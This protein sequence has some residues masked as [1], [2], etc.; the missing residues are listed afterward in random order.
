[1]A[2]P[3]INSPEWKSLVTIYGED[4]AYR[5][6]EANDQ[7][8]P[9]NIVTLTLQD[10]ERDLGLR[11]P[12]T[13]ER[14]TYPKNEMD[15]VMVM[16][17]DYNNLLGDSGFFAKL[18]QKDDMLSIGIQVDK[19]N[20]NNT[21]RPFNTTL[22]QDTLGYSSEAVLIGLGLQQQNKE[23][24]MRSLRRFSDP[25]LAT[26]ARNILK[27]NP[28]ISITFDTEQAT[29]YMPQG[30][31][32]NINPSTLASIAKNSGKFLPEVYEQ[33]LVHELVHS[34]TA[35]GIKNA[36]GI[37]SSK[38]QVLKELHAR[39][40]EQDNINPYT[41]EFRDT[42]EANMYKRSPQ[43]FVAEALSNPK[44]RDYL[45]EIPGG[46]NR[47][48]WGK[49]KDFILS[50]IFGTASRSSLY[51]NVFDTVFSNDQVTQS[52]AELKYINS[53]PGLN[54]DVS[55]NFAA[56]VDANE[57]SAKKSV[58]EKE[59]LVKILEKKAAIL[60]K[61]NVTEGEQSEISKRLSETARQL[62]AAEADLALFKFVE[63]AIT[64]TNKVYNKVKELREEG[65]TPEE[66][67]KYLRRLAEAYAY[68]TPFSEVE[69]TFDYIEGMKFGDVTIDEDYKRRVIAPALQNIRSVRKMYKEKAMQVLPKFLNEHNNDPTLD[70]S[71]IARMLT[72]VDDDIWNL[73]RWMSGIADSP[74]QVLAL[75]DRAVSYQRNR[76]NRS[77]VEFVNT[78]LKAV[79]K[80][81]EAYKASQGISKTDFRQYYDFM[82][83]KDKE[84]NL[85]GFYK[86]FSKKPDSFSDAEWNFYKLFIDNYRGSQNYLPTSNMRGLGFI[87]ILKSGTERR[88]SAVKGVKSAITQ[89]KE[90]L[91]DQFQRRVDDVDYAE[92]YIDEKG[93]LFYFLPTRYTSKIEADEIDDISLDLESNLARF[94][95]MARNYNAMNNIMT[96][97]EAAKFLVGERLVTNKKGGVP[98]VD[99]LLKQLRDNP[100]DP[101]TKH[102]KVGKDSNA[103]ARLSDY[104]DMVF[105][106]KRKE[107][108]GNIFGI[109]GLDKGK[110]LDAL[111]RFTGI[112]SLAFNLYSGINNATL[113]QVM[114]YI[115][116][117]SGQFYD[118]SDWFWSQG[119]YSKLVFNEFLSDS[120]R[121]YKEGK[122]GIWMDSYDI[123]QEFDEFGNP[124][125]SKSK[126]DTV[127]GG[128]S[129]FAQTSG[130]HMIQT[131]LAISMARH[132]R[133][134]NNEIFSYNDYLLKENLADT[135]ENKAKFEANP[136]VYDSLVLEEGKVRVSGGLKVGEMEKLSERIKGVF[137][138]LHG[139]Y[140]KKDI[141]ALN[142]W[143]LTRLMMMFRKWIKPGFDRR[144]AAGTFDGKFRF[145]QRLGANVIGTYTATWNFVRQLLKEHSLSLKAIAMAGRD[146]KNLPAWKQQ[147]I[148]RTLNEAMFVAGSFLVTA[149]LASIE[150]DDEDTP[151]IASMME[152]QSRRLNSELLFYVNVNDT[153]KI[154]RSPM[155][156]LSV[157][158]K[159]IKAVDQTMPWNI[160]EEYTRGKRTGEL[161]VYKRWGDLIPYYNQLERL[162][163]IEEQI[164][165]LRQ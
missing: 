124:L 102:T 103:Y 5:I 49:I 93:E 26:I 162:T 119:E 78:K 46:D 92:E 75:I 3:N 32:V 23:A 150:W 29:K 142:K 11:N 135:K 159:T 165:W 125:K 54:Y 12:D 57:K 28:D 136:N 17:N 157:V 41:D 122:I 73:T 143:G 87:A 94:M 25:Q 39:F 27:V 31:T 79:A 69:E 15:E 72:S 151:I 4:E 55:Y 60:A 38:G 64:E 40:L 48:L 10:K 96:E 42:K 161:K 144:F 45:N 121:R 99:K 145:D 83:E 132:H 37:T 30:N 114:N 71:D 65:K 134:I 163:R 51:D 68:I 104:L 146:F 47:T 106:G 13:N 118:K 2:C 116:G 63:F 21:D 85:T 35:L 91:A 153:L 149:V 34:I 115:E 50:F 130:E 24:V 56:S 107:D 111:G 117:A 18:I 82:L 120:T 67:R 95:T 66:N 126:L 133:I 158:E 156:S 155:A 98:I 89:G 14:I 36:G 84:G 43:E 74:D 22:K 123:L 112:T 16:V 80:D 154:M 147:A 109:K 53:V 138:Y 131:Q 152:Y 59:K 137:Q 6:F 7:T 97:V 9:A 127:V 108:E 8:L 58:D 88:L 110:A 86:A 77:V 76:V 105:Y 90:A 148:H 62:R 33:V 140:A 20:I 44:F 81:L 139:N 1:M 101:L 129:R 61:R 160:M 19:N 52:L 128:A 70:E 113:G 100:D 141:S 164:L